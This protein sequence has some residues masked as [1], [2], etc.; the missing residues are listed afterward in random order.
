MRI[1][2]RADELPAWM[3]FYDDAARERHEEAVHRARA[4]LRPGQHL[5]S[6]GCTLRGRG[7]RMLRAGEP[8]TAD[9]LEPRVDDDGR[10]LHTA[11]EAL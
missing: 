2:M 11:A 1:N 5:V 9:D 7:G 10:V 6:L 8:V 3:N 4:R